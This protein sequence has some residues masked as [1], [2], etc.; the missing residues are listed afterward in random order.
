MARCPQAWAVWTRSVGQCACHTCPVY[1]VTRDCTG[2]T[3]QCGMT[4]SADF[5]ASLARRHCEAQ[6]ETCDWLGLRSIARSMLAQNFRPEGPAIPQS[7][8]CSALQKY[9]PYSSHTEVRC[10][11]RSLRNSRLRNSLCAKCSQGV[12]M[13]VLDD[14][15]DMDR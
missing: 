15:F 10:V 12:G 4:F 2:R 6:G 5:F 3:R 11:L 8:C 13:N 9:M 1:A 14:D 7:R